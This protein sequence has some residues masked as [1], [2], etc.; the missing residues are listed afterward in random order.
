MKVHSLKMTFWVDV[1]IRTQFMKILTEQERK[2]NDSSTSSQRWSQTER[3]NE[4]AKIAI[5]EPEA[6]NVDLQTAAESPRPRFGDD[7]LKARRLDDVKKAEHKV[8][9]NNHAC[10]GEHVADQ[11]NA[12]ACF[13]LGHQDPKEM[14]DR[15]SI[16]SSP[17][18]GMHGYGFGSGEEYTL[19]VSKVIHSLSLDTYSLCMFY[20]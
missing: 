15:V 8:V 10:K 17:K 14:Q 3:K 2:K 7:D 16:S 6:D 20:L 9:S 1:G 12:A 18:T 11:L 13:S 5:S 4:S 19:E